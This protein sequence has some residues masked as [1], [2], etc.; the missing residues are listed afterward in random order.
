[1][2]SSSRAGRLA[3]ILF[4]SLPTCSKPTSRPSAIDLETSIL[5]HADIAHHK[6]ANFD[7]ISSRRSAALV[8]KVV[9]VPPTSIISLSL[10]KPF[11]FLHHRL[12]MSPPPTA[13]SSS[14]QENISTLLRTEVEKKNVPPY[15]ESSWLPTLGW[16]KVYF[17]LEFY[18]SLHVVYTS[19][20]KTKNLS[21]ADA[22]QSNSLLSPPV[23]SPRSLSSSSS[24]PAPELRTPHLQQRINR[25][26]QI[27]LLRVQ[28][29]RGEFRVEVGEDLR[30]GVSANEGREN[31][32]ATRSMLDGGWEKESS[33]EERTH[34]LASLFRSKATTRKKK[35]DGQLKL[36][37]KEEGQRRM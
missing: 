2:S 6:V 31:C 14:A 21:P 9:F 18:T 20:L 11:L 16:S 29:Q 25:R 7:A 8:S 10:P 33:G 13:L 30:E 22:P 24:I 19:S 35:R 4:F 36:M 17:W 3:S 32:S 27:S 1:L 23:H 5:P 37:R 28:D 26:R 15:F 34:K 12:N